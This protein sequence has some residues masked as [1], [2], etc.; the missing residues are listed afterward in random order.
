MVSKFMPE[1]LSVI[2]EYKTR[3]FALKY[4]ASLTI[5]KIMLA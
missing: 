3:G 2:L 1:V 5:L 4:Y